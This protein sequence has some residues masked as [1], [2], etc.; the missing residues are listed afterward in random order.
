MPGYVYAN[1]LD[2]VG[3]YPDVPAAKRPTSNVISINDLWEA[4]SSLP[5]AQPSIIETAEVMHDATRN[6]H[7]RPATR[8]A[9]K[10]SNPD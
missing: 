9:R 6:P 2:G 3:F 10:A 8:R 1:G 5:F 4:I 7:D